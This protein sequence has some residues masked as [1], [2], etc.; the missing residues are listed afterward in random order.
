MK[1]RDMAVSLLAVFALMGIGFSHLAVAGPMRIT[2]DDIQFPDMTTQNTAWISSGTDIYYNKGNV[3]IGESDPNTTLH[4]SDSDSDGWVA[5]IDKG[6]LGLSMCLDG[7]PFSGI[8]AFFSLVGLGPAGHNDLA[9]R[10]NAEPTGV[11]IKT[12]PGFIGI[13]TKSPEATLDVNGDLIVRGN[14]IFPETAGN[15]TFPDPAY[16]SGWKQISK[17]QNL[18]YIHNLGGDPDDYFVKMACRKV[19]ASGYPDDVNNYSYGSDEDYDWEQG[20]LWYGA[21]WYGLDSQS[22]TVLRSKD[23]PFCDYVSIKIWIYAD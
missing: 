5:S 1:K 19:S 13:H 22:V 15:M 14:M 21:V 23:D 4:V 16:S 11:Y 7:D 10:A 2:P 9:F 8:L 17:G 12:T 20:T 6:N 18:E 3:G